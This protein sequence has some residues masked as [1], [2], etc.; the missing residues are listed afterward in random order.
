M[1]L[2]NQNDNLD[3]LGMAESIIHQDLITMQK[4]Q[5]FTATVSSIYCLVTHLEILILSSGAGAGNKKI[6]LYI[7]PLTR[8]HHCVP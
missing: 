1:H 8:S 4:N 5:I 6:D 3:K 2:T 7:K